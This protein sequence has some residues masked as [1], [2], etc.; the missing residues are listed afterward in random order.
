MKP[1]CD[2]LKDNF[3]IVNLG[4][5]GDSDYQLPRSIVNALTVVE[6][7]AEGGA[8]TES[9]YHRKIQIAAPIADVAG[10]KTFIRNTFA[11]TC[12]L[13]RPRIGKVE[14]FGVEQYFNEVE[15]IE[16]ECETIPDLLRREK[17]LTLDF[18]KTDVEGL[19]A[20]IIQSCHAYYGKTLA[21]Q[22]E[23]RFDPFYETEP[24]FH[25]TVSLLASHGYEVLDIIHIDRWKYRTP[26]WKGQL[27]G[28]AVWADFIFFLK[29]E[30]LI[31]NFGAAAPL[32]IAKQIILAGMLG[33]KNYG[34]FLLQKFDAQLPEAWKAELR[35]V[36]K[37]RWLNL[38]QLR[39]SF[40]RQFMPLE[41]F[42]KH[43]INRSRHV[44][45]RLGN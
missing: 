43:R 13:L 45:V 39:K 30:K 38:T 15:S 25:E 32:A 33:K 28:R 37:P 35:L 27:E 19:D 41:L 3:T 14:Q 44:S 23:L 16:L 29:P 6:V 21:F 36:V 24:S 12:S 31:A 26:N 1:L 22:A 11:G 7:D 9:D 42:L 2:A 17:I 34:E 4:C 8:R 20:A 10:K 5:I 18:L 40:R